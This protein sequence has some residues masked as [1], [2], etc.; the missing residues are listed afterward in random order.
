MCASCPYWATQ[1]LLFPK[2]HWFLS[3]FISSIWSVFSGQKEKLFCVSSHISPEMSGTGSGQQRGTHCPNG[4]LK[5]HRS[6]RI[7]VLIVGT[8]V[9]V[10]L[11][12][13]LIHGAVRYFT[14]EGKRFLLYSQ[15]NTVL[16]LCLYV[17]SYQLNFSRY[18]MLTV[19]NGNHV[20]NICFWDTC[21]TLHKNCVG[22]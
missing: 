10:E 17:Y 9:R 12:V 18:S 15:I 1:P 4:A 6:P 16:D 14:T 5:C 8:S 7:D 20:E 22:N 11:A 2:E 21:K 13:P 3:S 19:L